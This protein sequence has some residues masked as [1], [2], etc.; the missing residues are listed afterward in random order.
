MLARILA[1]LSVFNI[2]LS[3][4][5]KTDKRV[6]KYD[7]SHFPNDDTS[8]EKEAVRFS[9]NFSGFLSIEMY[10]VIIQ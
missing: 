8:M 7:G 4:F 5:Q 9:C 2:N 3:V 6:A 1:V 10:I